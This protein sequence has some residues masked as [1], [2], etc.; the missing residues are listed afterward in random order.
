MAVKTI[1]ELRSQSETVR[2]ETVEEA[3]SAQRIGNNFLDIIDSLNQSISALQETVSAQ[4]ESISALQETVSTLTQSVADL[5][6]Q[7]DW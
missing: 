2:D 4:G 5:D 3:N 1:E 6:K 7:L